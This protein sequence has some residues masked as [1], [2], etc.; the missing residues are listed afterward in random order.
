MVNLWICIFVKLNRNKTLFAP[1]FSDSVVGDWCCCWYAELRN[2]FYCNYSG[3][4]NFRTIRA[5]PGVVI[6]SFLCLFWNFN[7]KKIVHSQLSEVITAAVRTFFNHFL[8]TLHKKTLWMKTADVPRPAWCT[9]PG[10]SECWSA[11][12]WRACWDCW[13]LSVW[14]EKC[15]PWREWLIFWKKGRKRDKRRLWI[16][17]WTWSG[18][19]RQTD[20]FRCR[21]TDKSTFTD[22][23]VSP[24][25]LLMPERPPCKR[26]LKLFDQTSCVR[27][28]AS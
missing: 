3:L 1:R 9:Y 16:M 7:Q 20:P 19:G 10:W 2:L 18:A 27:R 6:L 15:L 28:T 11:R 13:G 23:L 17:G 25:V 24:K 26:C 8:P 5:V 14:Q 4:I 22:A 12:W 21:R